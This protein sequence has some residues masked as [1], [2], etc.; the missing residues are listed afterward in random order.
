MARSGGPLPRRNVSGLRGEPDVLGVTPKQASR[1]SLRR[2]DAREDIT[3]QSGLVEWLARL[4]VRAHQADFDGVDIGLD[5][6]KTVG[7]LGGCEP[8]TLTKSGVCVRREARR[9]ATQ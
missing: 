1:R 9:R 4:E 8:P 5:R 6:E 2:P 7:D 3:Q